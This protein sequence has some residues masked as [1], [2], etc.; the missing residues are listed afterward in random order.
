MTS[1]RS[2]PEQSQWTMLKMCAM[3]T[4]KQGVTLLSPPGG[5]RQ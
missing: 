2:E 3:Q 1:G 5:E 4:G